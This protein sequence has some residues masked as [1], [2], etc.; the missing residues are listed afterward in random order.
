MKLFISGCYKCK[1]KKVK[2]KNSTKLVVHPLSS[3]DFNA[4]GQVDLI[5]MQSCPDG[6]YKFILNYQDH[7]TKFCVLGPLKTKTATEVA[8]HLLDIFTTFGTPAILQLDNGRESVAKVIEDLAGMWNGLHIVHGRPRHPQ[9]QGSVERSNHDAKQLLGILI[10]TRSAFN[11]VFVSLDLA[12]W[13]RE[14]SCKKWSQG[15][16]FV[17]SEEFMPSSCDKTQSIFSLIWSRTKSWF[18]INL[19]TSIDI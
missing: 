9:S 16:R 18:I 4:R 2:P 17:V 13:I 6:S 7:F 5:D 14:N 10:I 11:F 15:L 3:N 8:Y 12:T 19:F 1:I